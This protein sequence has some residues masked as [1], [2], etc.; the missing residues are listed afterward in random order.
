MSAL[1]RVKVSE[2]T[3]FVFE[4]VDVEVF[5][6]FSG[7]RYANLRAKARDDFRKLLSI[8]GADRALDRLVWLMTC[9]KVDPPKD[10]RRQQLLREE[11][12][13][14]RAMMRI[15]GAGGKAWLKR[16]TR[17][18]WSAEDHGALLD[19][20]HHWFIDALYSSCAGKKKSVRR[21]QRVRLEVVQV[22]PDARIPKWG[23]QFE[24]RTMVA[25]M[26]SEASGQT[27]SGWFDD[28]RMAGAILGVGE[29]QRRTLSPPPT[30][31][32]KDAGE[33]WVSDPGVRANQFKFELAVWDVYFPEKLLT[34]LTTEPFDSV[35]YETAFT[36]RV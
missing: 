12:D 34:S 16:A 9:G 15:A 2:N 36:H 29:V 22:H 32:K 10:D 14:H 30:R 25:R 3:P 20:S 24:P 6:D 31:W 1:Y 27:N 4:E 23:R 18:E 11:V 28:A 7:Y 33:W 26:V 8:D 21:G 5:A 19:M 17:K 13:A 35:A